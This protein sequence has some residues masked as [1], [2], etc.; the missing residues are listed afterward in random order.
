[1]DRGAGSTR[2]CTKC[3][4]TE[5]FAISGRCVACQTAR[6]SRSS[7]QRVR[8]TLAA[9]S[10]LERRAHEL[11][12][13]LVYERDRLER[14]R[15]RRLRRAADPSLALRDR[16]RGRLYRQAHADEIRA[17]NLRRTRMLRTAQ[18][19]PYDR[20]AIF[21]RDGWTCGLCQGPIDP[22]LVFPHPMSKSID[23]IV[24][25]SLGGD[26]SSDNVQAAH[27]GCNCAKGNR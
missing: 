11:E 25:L 6:A 22:A 10:L 14:A 24:P 7:D 9:L 20:E 15:R 16:E 13:Y 5:R 1:M 12:A 4:G 21:E 19:E 8:D 18:Q 23:H 2:P 27:L 3:G 17:R 26:D